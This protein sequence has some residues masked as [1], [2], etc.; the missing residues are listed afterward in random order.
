MAASA[1]LRRPA[2]IA[3]A[4]AA[5]VAVAI[6]SA[7]CIKFDVGIQL[8]D[9]GSGTVTVLTAF[10][11]KAL[12][13]FSKSLGGSSSSSSPADDLTKVDTSKLPAGTKV[14]KYK[15]SKYTGAKVTAPFKSPGDIAAIVNQIAESDSTGDTSPSAGGSKFFDKFSLVKDGGVWKF[16]AT[17]SA[18]AASSGGDIG[19]KPEDLKKLFKDASFTFRLKFPGGFGENNA[20]SSSNG[21]LTWKLDIFAS[22]ARTLTATSGSGTGG[23]GGGGDDFPILPVVGGGIVLIILVAGGAFLMMRRKPAAGA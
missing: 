21:E 12:D 19:L 1:S 14:E 13:D 6:L 18:P 8:N 15:D 10:D 5:L 7:A 11:T 3:L 16:S 23:D 17:V 20:D 9:D 22:S 4:A 2:R